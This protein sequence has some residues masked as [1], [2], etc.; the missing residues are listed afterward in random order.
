[1]NVPVEYSQ[2]WLMIVE[3]VLDTIFFRHLLSFRLIQGIQVHEPKDILDHQDR[4]GRECF[5]ECLSA[6]TTQTAL[7]GVLMVS[8]NDTD[9]DASF[10]AVQ[11]QI[12]QA[13]MTAPAT[14][15]S[16][17][18]QSDGKKL[19]VMMLP[20]T[21]V[22]GCLETL[23]LSA[24][25]DKWPD[26]KQPLGN[27]LQATPANDWETSP[28]SKMLFRCLT[29]TGCRRDPNAGM[30]VLDKSPCDFSLGHTCF[31]NM[32]NFLNQLPQ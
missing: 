27:Y 4:G 6:A 15:L 16:I 22:A 19:A 14:P 11:S 32:V 2:P 28:Q 31:D 29:A 10:R 8:D 21:S 5:S 9:P 7:K 12:R 26:L 13:G 17:V 20:W 23:C 18:D 24:A 25:Y 3:G 30:R 1:V